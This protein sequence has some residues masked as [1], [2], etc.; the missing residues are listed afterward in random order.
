MK[1]DFKRLKSEKEE[2]VRY[3]QDVNVNERI[4]TLK[5]KH[6]TDVKKLK[7]NFCDKLEKINQAKANWMKEEQAKR[8]SAHVNE[9]LIQLFF[10]SNEKNYSSYRDLLK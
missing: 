5:E 8:V 4:K 3:R 6:V 1:E 10:Y 9:I 7:K 2:E